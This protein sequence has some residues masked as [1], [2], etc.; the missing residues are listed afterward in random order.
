MFR[1]DLFQPFGDDR[2]CRGSDLRLPDAIRAGG[3]PIPA[4][5]EDVHYLTRNGTAEVTFVSGLVP[6]YLHRTGLLPDGAD[7]FDQRYGTKAVAGPEIPLPD[8]LCGSALRGPVRIYGSQGST[9][10]GSGLGVMVECSD[11]P[12]GVFRVPA[13]A[14][15]AFSLG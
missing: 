2:A 13:R 10:T 1:D 8:G 12:G 14:V 3:V 4:D 9:G 6:E 5:A 15:I 7:P 11:V